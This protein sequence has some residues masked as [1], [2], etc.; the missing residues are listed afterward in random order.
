MKA[1]TQRQARTGGILSP[2]SVNA[3]LRSAVTSV[4]TMDRDQLPA[5]AFDASNFAAGALHRVWWAPRW[6]SESVVPLARAG[7]Q[8]A[9]RD[10]ATP[11]NGWISGTYQTYG[12]GWQDLTSTPFVAN[13]FAGGYFWVEWSGIGYPFPA[14]SD[15]L[16]MEKPGNPKYINLRILANGVLL[17]ERRGVAYHERFRVTGGTPLPQGDVQVTFQFRPTPTGPDDPLETTATDAVP[18]FHLYGNSV[19]AIGRHR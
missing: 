15:T 1:W 19:L 9:V 16:N 3:E 12:G 2:E 7:E 11:N 10:S 5:A 14:F 8:D 17:C 13:G 4:S 6:P 18:Q